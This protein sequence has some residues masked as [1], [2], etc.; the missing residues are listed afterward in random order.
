MKN[1]LDIQLVKKC[2]LISSKKT[3]EKT[4]VLLYVREKGRTIVSNQREKVKKEKKTKKEKRRKERKKDR[5]TDRQT[6][7]QRERQR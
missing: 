7:R 4:I 5:E 3:I 2:L 6:K 1:I